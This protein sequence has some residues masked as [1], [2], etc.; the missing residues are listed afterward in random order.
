MYYLAHADGAADSPNTNG[1]TAPDPTVTTWTSPSIYLDDNASSARRA[2][3]DAE[4]LDR[5]GHAPRPTCRCSTNLPYPDS[6]D[7]SPTR[8]SRPRRQ[9]FRCRRR[10][11]GHGRD[12]LA[13]RT[14]RCWRRRA[15]LQRHRPHDRGSS[16][17]RSVVWHSDIWNNV[18]RHQLDGP[19]QRRRHALHDRRGGRAQANVMAVAGQEHVDERGRSD[20]RSGDVPRR[21]VRLAGDRDGLVAAQHRRQRLHL[22]GGAATNMARA[23]RCRRT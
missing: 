6:T 22:S 15:A 8:R 9:P 3:I 12:G 1:A 13:A 20:G 11:L 19:F 21:A 14:R 17:M 23:R 10:L 7:L 4:V 2:K 5:L 18:A 16:T